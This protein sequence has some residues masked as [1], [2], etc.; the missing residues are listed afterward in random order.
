MHRCRGASRGGVEGEV[1]VRRLSA[2]QEGGNRMDVM[3]LWRVASRCKRAEWG[4][5]TPGMAVPC[6]SWNPWSAFGAAG[7]AVFAAACCSRR[8][9]IPGLEM[10]P[11]QSCGGIQEC[12]ATVGKSCIKILDVCKCVIQINWVLCFQFKRQCNRIN[13]DQDFN[14]CYLNSGQVLGGSCQS[15]YSRLT[16]AVLYRSY[17]ASNHI[18][19]IHVNN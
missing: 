3:R 4:W 11:P 16:S 5:G 13:V 14:F 10:G 2:W 9:A 6:V 8:S 7:C 18:L 12:D 17:N 19:F 1:H 15:S